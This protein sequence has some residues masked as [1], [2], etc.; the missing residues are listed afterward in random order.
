MKT[1]LKNHITQF[2]QIEQKLFIVI[3]RENYSTVC[4]SLLNVRDVKQSALLFTLNFI[5]R[6]PISLEIQFVLGS[7]VLTFARHFY[8]SE[9]RCRLQFLFFR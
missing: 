2:I 4:L 8:Q 9:T 7:L 1:M 3:H 5:C 6:R